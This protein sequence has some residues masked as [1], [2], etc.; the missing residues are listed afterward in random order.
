MSHA[1]GISND[2]QHFEVIDLLSEELSQ[3]EADLTN[4]GIPSK[5]E[6]IDH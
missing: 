3:L 4:P 2:N 6:T 5:L 1:A